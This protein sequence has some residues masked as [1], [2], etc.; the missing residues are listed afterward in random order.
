MKIGLITDIHENVEKLRE[1]IKLADIQNCDELVCLGDI[2]GYDHR[3]YSFNIS[4]SAKKMPRSYQVKLPVDCCR[5][6]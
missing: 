4:R 2:V 5:E 6:P 1:A 3:F